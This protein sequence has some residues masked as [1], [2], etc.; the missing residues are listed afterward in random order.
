MSEDEI[1]LLVIEE[2]VTQMMKKLFNADYQEMLKA[3][4]KVAEEE[5]NNV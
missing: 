2:C 1:R 3:V 5:D 4:R